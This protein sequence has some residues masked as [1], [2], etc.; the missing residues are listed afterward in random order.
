MRISAAQ[1]AENENRVPAAIGPAPARRGPA[2][3]KARHQDP[4]QRGRG[5]PHRVLRHPPL[6]SPPRRV[7]T[8]PERH[9]RGRRDPRSSRSPGSPGSRRRTPIS[10]NGSPSPSRCS[11]SSPTSAARPWPGSPP[12]M[13]RSSGSARSPPGHPSEPLSRTANHRDRKLQLIRAK[14]RGESTWSCQS[15][16]RKTSR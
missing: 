14:Q 9:A 3:W 15:L 8:P 4:C 5:R 11:T 10:G 7:R 2:W 1:R 13:N 16:L 6:R 12:N